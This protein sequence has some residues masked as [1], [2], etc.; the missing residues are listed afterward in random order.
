VNSIRSIALLTALLIAPAATSAQHDPLARKCTTAQVEATAAVD[1]SP[2]AEAL[3][4][5]NELLTQGAA[6]DALSAF[7]QSERFADEAA[8]PDL[9]VRATVSAARAAAEVES[10]SDASSRLE[11]AT[12]RADALENQQERAAL[13]IHLARSWALLA[14]H[15]QQ[16]R[17]T[18]R[19]RA[20]HTL[21][22]AAKDAEAASDERL[23]SYALGYLAAYYEEEGRRDEAL[24]LTRRALF[25]AQQ[26]D[27]PDAAY[28]WNWQIGRLQLADGDHAAALASY[29]RAV[30]ALADIRAQL[31]TSAE[32]TAAFRT[33]VKPLYL[34]LVDLLLTRSG[35]TQGDD[36]QALL[37]EARGTL[38]DLK[39]AELRDYFRD[40]CL[41]AQRKASPDVIPRTLVIYPVA[42]PDRLEL[43]VGASGRLERFTVPVGAEAFAAEI[44]EFRKLLEKRTTRQFL[45][46]ARNLYDWLIRPIEPALEGREIDTLVFVPEGLL[47]TVPLAALQ[48]RESKQYLIERYALAITP[49]LTLT[50]PRPIDRGSVRLLAA[51]I[52]ESVQGY[53]ALEA[54][55][56]E[57]A[58][59]GESFPGEQLMNDSFRAARF[60]SEVTGKPFGIIHIASHGEFSA[61]SAESYVL[62]FDGRMSMDQLADWVATTRFRTE[63]PLE[64]LT[65]SA[66]ETASGDE[67][68]AL[69]LAGVALRAGARSALATLWSV[70]DQASA[71]LISE[72]YTQLR[73]PKIS[74]ADALQAAQVKILRTRHF[75][76]PGYWA[77]FVLISSWL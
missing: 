13:R 26:A 77:P 46:P 28:R 42:L 74:R 47:R 21:Q 8:R 53:P 67:R 32:G 50:E 17:Q 5:G 75:R 6:A 40:P 68:A 57:I 41:D 10:Q 38:E 61:D 66:C 15:H 37:A 30:T 9:A 73:D 25:A 44:L 48:D 7:E 29:R 22:Q 52:S 69:G 65:L 1:H 59:V 27:A 12:K 72:F 49:S 71:D 60:E 19:E 51:G 70:Q 23:R 43:I 39:V 14:Q 11:R 36:Q 62:T 31:A 2:A 55:A 54:V 45:R 58:V 33:S 3:T 64:L 76:H 63:H 34:A 56:Q 18:A 35:K 20:V 16:A 4:R 24:V